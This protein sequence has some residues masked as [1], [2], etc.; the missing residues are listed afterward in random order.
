MHLCPKSVDDTNH[1]APSTIRPATVLTL[2]AHG[3]PPRKEPSGCPSVRADPRLK[4][5]PRCQSAVRLGERKHLLLRLA[6]GLMLGV[7][8][9]DLLPEARRTEARAERS[10]VGGR[11]LISSRDRHDVAGHRPRELDE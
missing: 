2:G 11:R 3:A 4:S 10:S 6:A 5:E 7:F 8:A 9:F 1:G